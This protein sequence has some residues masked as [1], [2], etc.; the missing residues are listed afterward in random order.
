M[1]GGIIKDLTLHCMID[2]ANDGTL[3]S[4]PQ[5]MGSDSREVRRNQDTINTASVSTCQP[6]IGIVPWMFIEG[7]GFVIRYPATSQFYR[8]RAGR[9]LGVCQSV[10]IG[11]NLDPSAFS[12]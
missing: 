4:A 9:F 10:G 5:L 6:L 11:S 3:S 8:M 1:P 7:R 2:S 12:L